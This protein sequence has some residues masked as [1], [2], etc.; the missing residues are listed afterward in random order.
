MRCHA[1]LSPL[2][3]SNKSVSVDGAANDCAWHL[4]IRE[5]TFKRKRD[6]ILNPKVIKIRLRND[7][8]CS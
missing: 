7:W 1:P 4:L 6:K 3:K 2:Y 8:F 5:L